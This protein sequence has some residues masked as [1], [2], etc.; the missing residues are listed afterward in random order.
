MNK[1]LLDLG[2]NKFIEVP[3]DIQYKIIQDKLI[4]TYYWSVGFLS[5]IV[6]FLLGIIAAK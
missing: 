5:T 4:S 1:Y 3:K 2:D 6:G